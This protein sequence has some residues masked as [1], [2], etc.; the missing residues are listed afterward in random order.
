MRSHYSYSSLDT[1]RVC[2]RRFKYAY[3][4]RV[5]VPKRVT[6]DTYLGQAVHRTLKTLYTLGADGI[7]MPLDDA[8]K[9]YLAEW[10]KLDRRVIKVASEYYTVDDYIRIGRELLSRHYQRYQPFDHG[11]L[12][13]A[14]MHLRFQLPQTPFKFTCY[15]DR[16]W[17]RDD[18]IVEICDYKTGQSFYQ[19]GDPKFF[20]QMGLYQLAVQANYPQYQA[21]ELAQYFLRKDEI[22][23]CRLDPDQLQELIEMLRLA[24]VETIEA[25]Q[26][27]D[28]PAREGNHCAYCDYVQICPAKIHRRML[29]DEPTDDRVD[30][31]SAK[32]IKQLADEYLA[33]YI[34]SSEV[35]GELDGLKARLIEIARRYD[36]SKFEGT[37]GRVSVSLRT[38]LEFV[39]KTRDARAFAE[40]N[41]LGRELGLDG[42][43]VID[44]RK[45]MSDVY[46]K[47]RLPAEQLEKLSKYVSE[48]DRSRVTSKLRHEPDTDKE[49]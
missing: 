17:K 32:E 38:A 4:D 45:L 29:D 28:F 20:G 36:V 41:A 24:V 22:V 10:D 34:Q 1:F 3:V 18:G 48:A 13:G 49:E 47:E 19:S 8:V 26:R 44:S 11:T 27:D 15:I 39:T 23:S 43:F 12:L 46:L 40:L 9:A 14:E 25:T 31:L 5:S 33:K 16:L 35:K 7:V 42:Y 2:P 30:D 21:I 6:A 37:L